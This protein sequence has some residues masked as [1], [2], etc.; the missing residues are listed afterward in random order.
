[1]NR[2]CII[3]SLILAIS[4]CQN[5]QMCFNEATESLVFNNHGF[6]MLYFTNDDNLETYFVLK[7]AGIGKL[8]V[9][10]LNNIDTN[11]VLCKRLTKIP[12]E[13]K[14]SWTVSNQSNG[15]AADY[16]IKFYINESGVFIANKTCN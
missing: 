3:S 9:F 1:M 8:T 6:R 2:L 10:K 4:G 14:S 11:S 5:N 13:P 7:K 15:D 16:R 12:F